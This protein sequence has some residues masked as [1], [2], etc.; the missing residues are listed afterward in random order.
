MTEADEHSSDFLAKSEERT[1]VFAANVFESPGNDE[2]SF[3][4]LQ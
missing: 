4:F 1:S 2:M 3:E